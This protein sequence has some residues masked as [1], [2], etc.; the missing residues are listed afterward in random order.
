ML[1]PDP[2]ERGRGYR[3]L[4]GA[5]AYPELYPFPSRYH[6][7]SHPLYLFYKDSLRMGFAQGRG[8]MDGDGIHHCGTRRP[9]GPVDTQ[10]TLL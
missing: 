9:H 6:L 1:Y 7:H 2:S 5:S 3:T 8:G 4:Q 10:Q